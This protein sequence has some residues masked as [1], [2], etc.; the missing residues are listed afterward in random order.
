[1]LD[2]IASK[3]GLVDKIEKDEL[4]ETKKGKKILKK[5]LSELKPNHEMAARRVIRDFQNNRLSYFT[6]APKLTKK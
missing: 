4:V 1:M 5:V 3:K 2:L 6:K